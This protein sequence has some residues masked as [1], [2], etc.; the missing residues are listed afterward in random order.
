MGTQARVSTPKLRPGWRHA[1]ASSGR[2]DSPGARLELSNAFCASSAVLLR[3]AFAA[4]RKRPTKSPE[5]RWAGA[6]AGRPTAGASSPGLRRSS[7]GAAGPPSPGSS[8]AS[9]ASGAAASS[10]SAGTLEPPSWCPPPSSAA[11]PGAQATGP[12]P[13]GGAAPPASACPGPR[14]RRSPWPWR[15]GRSS[16]GSRGWGY[17]PASRQGCTSTWL[18]RSSSNA[19]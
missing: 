17:P 14:R 12:P 5:H 13:R 8:P 18:G 9:S 19:W 7:P 10:S 1:G 16:R 2:S 3:S 11:A 6:L 15:A 4:K